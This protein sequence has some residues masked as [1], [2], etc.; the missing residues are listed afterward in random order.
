MHSQFV[1][2]DFEDTVVREAVKAPKRLAE[3][4]KIVNELDI[5]IA[6]IVA[7][8]NETLIT[9][10]KDILNFESAKIIVL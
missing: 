9:R 8:N 3:K 6:G 7:A 4:G 1:I 10:D 2:Y 5:L